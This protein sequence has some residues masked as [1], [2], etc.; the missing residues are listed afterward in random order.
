MMYILFAPID[1]PLRA[2][3]FLFGLLHVL[4][5]SALKFPATWL[6]GENSRLHRLMV[7]ANLAGNQMANESLTGDPDQSIC[8][9]AAMAVARGPEGRPLAYRV[10][11]IWCRI[12][13]LLQERHCQRALAADP[14]EGRRGI[15]HRGD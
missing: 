1:L 9:R 12:M 10:A 8:A 4:I 13:A 11:L 14:G 6:A 3:R 5:Y 2:V 15:F 7:N